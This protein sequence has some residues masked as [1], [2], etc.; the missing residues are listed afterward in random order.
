MKYILLLT[1]FLYG[2]ANDIG[3]VNRL[4][5]EQAYRTERAE[6]VKIIY[7]DSAKV[8]VKITAPEM[9]RTSGNKI[10]DEFPKGIKI[11]FL[12]ESGRPTS[13]LIAESAI[14]DEVTRRFIA[15]GK[16]KFYN[17]QNDALESSELTWYEDE[18]YLDTEKFIRIVQPNRGDTSYG[19]GFKTNPE[20]TRFEIKKKTKSKFN[21]ER[22]KLPKK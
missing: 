3:E 12:S 6:E 4:T 8:L 1:L 15:K 10:K 11:E 17:A 20:F 13:W 7:S 19:Y 14:R 9:I 5:E 21:I 2:C 16:V 22:L 18:K